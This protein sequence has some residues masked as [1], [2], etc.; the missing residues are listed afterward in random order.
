M[1][2]I[3]GVVTILLSIIGHAPY[4]MDVYKKKTR[5]HVFTWILWAIVVSIAFFGQWFKGG[6]AGAWGT[7]VTGIIVIVIAVL[8]IR[9]GTKDITLSD[10]IFLGLALLAIIPWYL[11]RDPTLSVVMASFIDLCAFIPTIRKTIKDPKS[12]TQFTYSL[13]ILRHGLS[14]FALGSYNLATVLYP[15]YLLVMNSVMTVI[16]IWKPLHSRIQSKS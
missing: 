14:I 5:P 16:I 8:A 15:A 6:G 4:V 11:T 2:E 12:E 1:K 13:N 7:G 10:K 3:L 9:R